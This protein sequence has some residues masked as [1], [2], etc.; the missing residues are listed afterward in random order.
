MSNL[1]LKRITEEEVA[2]L[3]VISFYTFIDTFGSD[4]PASD[5]DSYMTQAYEYEQ[6]NSELSNP[7][8]QFY[9]LYS[10]KQLAGYLKLNQGA[11]QSEPM[12]NNYFEIERIYILPPF[13]RKG[14]GSYLLSFAEKQAQEAGKNF[15]WLGV[16]E[17]NDQAQ[18]F[19]KARGFQR[20]SEHK[21]MMGSWEQI[22]WL[23]GKRIAN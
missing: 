6:L 15:I 7:E 4:T 22:D 5:L 14:L 19:Y 17:F 20:F 9:F 8:S 21:F 3:R 1:E 11:A 18:A 10:D 23:L 12:P 16:W 2:L 13:K